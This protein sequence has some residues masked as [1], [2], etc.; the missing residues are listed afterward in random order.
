MQCAT[1]SACRKACSRTRRTQDSEEAHL[2]ALTAVLE[3]SRSPTGREELAAAGTPRELAQALP[4]Y[5][6]ACLASRTGRAA[7]QLLCLLRAL[8]NVCAGVEA[9]KEQLHG[10]ACWPHLAQLLRDLAREPDLPTR[11]LLLATA[12]QALGNAC[13]QQSCN[14]AAAWCVPVSKPCPVVISAC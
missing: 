3:Q 1:L 9:A 8:R 14:Q 7:E 4:R 6:A 5:A 2:R 12:L 13:V 10:A 11:G